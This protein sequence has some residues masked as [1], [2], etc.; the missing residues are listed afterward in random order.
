MAGYVRPGGL[1]GERPRTSAGHPEPRSAGSWPACPTSRRHRGGA[2]SSDPQL[3]P[4]VEPS[5][6]PLAS[7]SA[8]LA[9]HLINRVSF[10]QRAVSQAYYFY[11][12]KSDL[13]VGSPTARRRSTLKNSSP[14]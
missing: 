1:D 5:S 6:F 10:D 12:K 4:P 9:C 7:G 8:T 3:K 13:G 2:G 14:I 11:V